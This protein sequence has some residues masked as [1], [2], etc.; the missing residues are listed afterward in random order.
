MT[1][2]ELEDFIEANHRFMTLTEMMEATGKVDKSIR[3]IVEKRGF[4]VIKIGERTI[5][6]IRRHPHMSFNQLLEKLELSEESLG[7]YLVKMG[8]ARVKP[9]LRD[10]PLK[11]MFDFAEAPIPVYKPSD[12]VAAI[13]QRIDNTITLQD[14]AGHSGPAWS[15]Y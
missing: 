14:L 1:P 9:K 6:Y 5:Q 4:N 3:Y 13:Y 11:E 2:K 15:S 12:Q 7:G 8:F 10:T